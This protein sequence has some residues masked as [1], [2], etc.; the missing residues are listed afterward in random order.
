MIEVKVV[1]EPRSDA[2]SQMYRELV[3]KYGQDN[4]NRAVFFSEFVGVKRLAYIKALL[5]SGRLGQT[6]IMEKRRCHMNC[7]ECLKQKLRAMMEAKIKQVTDQPS[8]ASGQELLNIIECAR[9]F[10]QLPKS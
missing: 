5:L 8:T 10:V 7:D 2:E 6:G 3:E 4:V 9:I 1:F